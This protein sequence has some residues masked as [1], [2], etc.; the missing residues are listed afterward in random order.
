VNVKLSLCFTKHYA[1]TKYWWWRY[2]STFALDGGECSGSRP[3][4]FTPGERT[5][6]MDWIGGWVGPRTSLRYRNF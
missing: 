5:S 2:N 6:G 4:C 3:G 1:I